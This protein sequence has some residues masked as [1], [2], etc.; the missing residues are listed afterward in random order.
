MSNKSFLTVMARPRRLGRTQ[1]CKMG[2]IR[3][4]W[5]GRGRTEQMTVHT[6]HDGFSYYAARLF[7]VHINIYIQCRLIAFV[8]CTSK[9]MCKR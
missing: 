1:G 5:L 8:I 3:L 4:E 7:S 6:K 2:Y 9:K